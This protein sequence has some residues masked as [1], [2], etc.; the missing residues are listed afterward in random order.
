M[1]KKLPAVHWL[2]HQTTI[3]IRIKN[4]YQIRKEIV[5][6]AERFETPCSIYAPASFHKFQGEK[7]NTE[8]IMVSLYC[9]AV[10]KWL[11]TQSSNQCFLKAQVICWLQFQ[12]KNGCMHDFS[13]AGQWF[14][15]LPSST[16]T[17]NLLFGSNFDLTRSS[18]DIGKFAKRFWGS[19]ESLLYLPAAQWL[20]TRF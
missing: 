20:L 17:S 19:S 11:P 6:A 15:I 1:Q 10:Y 7:M 8:F 16:K 4:V 13:I 2:L 5:L 9:A 18:I 3:L 14:A 12:C